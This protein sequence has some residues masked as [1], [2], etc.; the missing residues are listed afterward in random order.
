MLNLAHCILT[1]RHTQIHD[2]KYSN[3][4]NY[5]LV[6]PGTLQPLIFDK[7]ADNQSVIIFALILPLRLTHSP[8]IL[9]QKGISTYAI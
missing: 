3:D 5:L 4:G 8:A 6:I 7:N 9:I 1:R 2:L